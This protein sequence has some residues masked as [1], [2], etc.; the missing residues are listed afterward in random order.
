MGTR[1]RVGDAECWVKTKQMK[2]GSRWRDLALYDKQTDGAISSAMLSVEPRMFFSVQVRNLNCE[3]EKKPLAF[4]VTCGGQ[5][6][7]SF[8]CYQGCVNKVT[9][10]WITDTAA[11]PLTFATCGNPPRTWR[12]LTLK[13]V[14]GQQIRQ[15]TTA[16]CSSRHSRL[17]ASV[18]PSR[19]GRHVLTPRNSP[20]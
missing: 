19:P 2:A 4:R 11:S 7:D 3:D 20:S 6:M 1:I 15:R 13:T 14:S 16:M 18:R 5:L 12:D 8:L 10:W 17:W 9:H